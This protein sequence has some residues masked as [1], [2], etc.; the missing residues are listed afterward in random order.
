MGFWHTGY[1]EFHEPSGL[2]TEIRSVIQYACNECDEIFESTDQLRHHRFERHPLRRPVLFVRGKEVGAHPVHIARM[3][4]PSDIVLENCEEVFLNEG[5]I[6][7]QALPTELSKI[8][9]DTCNLRLTKAG[10][11]AE[12]TLEFRV[13]SEGDIKGIENA[14]DRLAKGRR[15]NERVVSDFIDSTSLYGSA[16]RYC[17]GISGYLF[18]A[19]VKEGSLHSHLSFERYVDKFNS[20]AVVLADYERPLARAIAGIIAFHFNQFKGVV[21]IAAQTRVGAAATRFNRLLDG[22]TQAS[23]LSGNRRDKWERMITDLPTERIIQ[24]AVQPVK[25]LASKIDEVESF[26]ADNP[27]EFDRP[28]LH[29]LLGE[30][31]TSAGNRSEARRH[32]AA[33]RNIPAFENWAEAIIRNCS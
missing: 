32:A 7:P 21:S 26:L 2:Q 8:T 20:A 25:E 9:Y 33:L 31:H 22:T 6:S 28:K 4:D 24:W 10:V 11:A 1:I 17:D 15:L 13:A 5:K 3:L 18:G 29:L 19:L 23:V 12:F 27:V 14:F 30:A 16:I